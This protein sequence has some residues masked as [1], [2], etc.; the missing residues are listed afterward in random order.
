[1]PGPE[2]KTVQPISSR[3][4]TYAQGRSLSRE[5]ASSLPRCRVWRW[6]SRGRVPTCC[7]SPLLFHLCCPGG[8]EEREAE[9][10]G[11]PIAN[12]APGGGVAALSPGS[13][14]QKPSTPGCQNAA[15]ACLR[16]RA[17]SGHNQL[18]SLV[19]KH[20][21]VARAFKG[22]LHRMISQWIYK[23]CMFPSPLPRRAPPPRV[24]GNNRHMPARVWAC[25]DSGLLSSHTLSKVLKKKPN[26]HVAFWRAHTHTQ[27]SQYRSE[28]I[29]PRAEKRLPSLESL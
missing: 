23:R 9:A 2:H 22:H 10:L 29:I 12:A 8:E 24:R 3:C 28:E 19:V 27:S 16:L 14:E 6:D 4:L 20:F 13:C 26:T 18:P 1:M 17:H 25:R 7:S 15:T 21:S 5:A 11:C